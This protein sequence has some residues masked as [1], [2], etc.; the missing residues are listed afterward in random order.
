VDECEGIRSEASIM[1]RPGSELEEA[2]RFDEKMPF[3]MVCI[4]GREVICC[5]EKV[6]FGM[7]CVSAHSIAHHLE[8]KATTRPGRHCRSDPFDYINNYS[9]MHCV[10]H[11]D[12]T[13][14]E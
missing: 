4:L 6:Q 9:K 11:L 2:I 5:D 14:D 10:Q 7:V 12:I 3:G 13:P 8:L 1:D